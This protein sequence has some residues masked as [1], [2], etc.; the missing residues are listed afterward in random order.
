MFHLAV[1]N[2]DQPDDVLLTDLRTV[3]RKLSKTILRRVDYATHGRF[4][5]ATVANRFGGWGRALERAGLGSARHFGVSREE[6]IADLRRVATELNTLEL[7]LPLYRSRGKYSDKPFVHHFGGWV[8]ALA[9]AG[10]QASEF[11]NSRTTDESLYEN[12][13]LVWQSLGR[14]PTVNDMHSPLSRY[15]AHTYKRRFGGWRKALESFVAAS[16]A[17]PVQSAVE[18][19]APLPLAAVPSQPEAQAGR[20]RSVGWRLRYLVLSRDRFTCKACGRSPATQ[21]G[22]CLQVDHIVPWSKGGPTVAKNLQTLCEQ[23]NGGKGAV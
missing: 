7:S 18:G 11:F 20:S 17:Q 15:S 23:C 12:L 3:A 9:A 5:P 22:L 16:S 8:S 19:S 14:Q 10:L 4:A 13:E 6:A 21:P 1:N 2:R